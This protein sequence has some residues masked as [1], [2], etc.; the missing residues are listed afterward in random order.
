MDVGG[1]S[2]PSATAARAATAATPRMST[3][4]T[5]LTRSRNDQRMITWMRQRIIDLEKLMKTK[6]A[7]IDK[8]KARPAPSTEREL[9]LL[10]EI[11]LISQQLDS[12]YLETCYPLSCVVSCVWFLSFLSC[13]QRLTLT[14]KLKIVE[15]SSMLPKRRRETPR[16][17]NTSGLTLREPRSWLGCWIECG[18]PHS[19]YKVVRQLC[20]RS[21]VCCFRITRSRKVLTP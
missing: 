5:R 20:P 8:M 3:R 15:C 13:L 19:F 14:S 9:Y 1:S 2:Q 16:V 4:R 7:E 21:I 12:E 18:V 17:C 11:E 6:Q 10:S